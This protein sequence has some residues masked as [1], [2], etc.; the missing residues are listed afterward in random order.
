MRDRLKLLMLSKQYR[1][2]IGREIASGLLELILAVYGVPGNG[3]TELSM[4]TILNMNREIGM[5]RVETFVRVLKYT[6]PEA[7][8]ALLADNVFDVLSGRCHLHGRRLPSIV[9]WSKWCSVYRLLNAW[10]SNPSPPEETPTSGPGASI[11]LGYAVL[12]NGPV[13]DVILQLTTNTKTLDDGSTV[14]VLRNRA[15][16]ARG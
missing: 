14:T 15:L 12:C 13:G 4:I 9:I 6:A 5:S 10:R 1:E 16:P 11:G 3:I 2:T 7:E 8:R